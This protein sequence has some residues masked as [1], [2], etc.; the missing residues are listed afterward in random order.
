MSDNPRSPVRLSSSIQMIFPPLCGTPQRNNSLGP[1]M[2]RQPSPPSSRRACRSENLHRHR[3][4]PA[5]SNSIRASGDLGSMLRLIRQPCSAQALFVFCEVLGPVRSDY[6][7]ESRNA[8]RGVELPQSC[9]RF[10][11]LL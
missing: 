11:R 6:V 5:E 1:Q 7:F 10:R 3:R 4:R 9:H 8:Q 2:R